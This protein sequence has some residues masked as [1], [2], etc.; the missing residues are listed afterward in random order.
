M[1]EKYNITG[2]T[3]SACSTHVTKAIEKLEGTQNVTVNLL[4]NSLTLDYDKDKLSEKDIIEAV[5]KAGYGASSSKVQKKES[6]ESSSKQ[7][8]EKEKNELKQRFTVSL[9]FAVPLVYIAMG[10]MLNWPMPSIMMGHKNAITFIFTQFLLLI[11]IVYVNKSYF[12][13]GFKS[14]ANKAPNMDSLI[15]IGASAAII[16]GIF[17]IYM[18][19]Y[20]LG[21]QNM[22]IVKTYH[23]DVY[24]ESA[25]VILTLITLG[26]YFEAKSKGKTSEALEKLMDLAPKTAFIEINNEIKEVSVD[27]VNVGD[28][29]IIKP[30]SLIPVDGIII[31]GTTSID[32][33]AITGESIP[34]EKEIGSK[35]IQATINKTGYVKIKTTSVK[36]DTVFSKILKLVEDASSTKAPIAK[37]ADK[38]SGIFVPVV[39]VISIITAITWLA[40]GQTFEF[41]LSSA[42]SVLVISC[43]CALGLAT[44]VAIMVGTGKGAENGILIKSG[45]ALELAHEIQSVILDKTGTI[46]QGKPVVTDVINIDID[47]EELLTIAKSLEVKSEHPLAE[48]IVEYSKNHSELQ[49]NNFDAISGKGVKAQ[50]ND[51]NY[52]AGNA[53]LMSENNIDIQKYEDTIDKLSDEGKTALLFA[54]EDKLIG[55][56]AVADIIKPTSKQAIQMLKK[57]G[58]ET[59]MLTGD[60]QKTANGIAK[61]LNLDKVIAEV[62]PQD[63]EKV[64]R[65]IQKTGR[66]VAMVGDGINDAPALVSSDVGIAIGSGTDIAV[67]SADIVLMRNDLMDVVN[68]IK[69]SKATIT[70]IKQNL[71]WAF[72]YN[73]LG[74][75]LAAGLLFPVFGLRLSPMFGAGA[76]GF[77]SVFVVSNALRLKLFKIERKTEKKEEIKM[78]KVI[79]I[80]GMSC[81]HC[82]NHVVKAINALGLETTVSLEEKNAKIADVKDVSDETIAK[83][84]IDAGYTV[85]NIK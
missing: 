21:I 10:S 35:V 20:G 24:F 8:A 29:V 23:M 85:T 62:L 36:E 70:N 52:F 27:E 32:E 73:S 76:M 41:A 7:I 4:T 78:E 66:K 55:I 77:S 30:G 11:P 61:G 22:D 48:A 65:D 38:V 44:P 57:M 72:F 45:E 83:A 3:C 69:L 2:M 46:T 16:Y 50:I 9:I 63:K 58:I 5:E 79:G 81:Q 26:K 12:I 31:E 74:I 75:P 49:T 51:V 33:S 28:I 40:L 34:A 13:R 71:F 67:E 82:V 37:M 80:E 84:I 60:N 6:K 42:I 19:G 15:A 43:P 59:I 25:G 18:I 1:S 14:L 56:I 17:A 54:K 64:V 68:A 47:K 53:R 39:I